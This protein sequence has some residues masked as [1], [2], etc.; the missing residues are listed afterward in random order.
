M[1]QTPNARP[2]R[3]ALVDDYDV[4]LA[5]LA[6]MFDHYADRIEV[7]EIDVNT[8]LKAHVDIALYDSFAQP[9]TDHQEIGALVRSGRADHVVV[10]TWNFQP[11]LVAEASKIGISGYLSKTLPARDLVT[12]LEAVHAGEFVV[13]DVPRRAGAVSGLDWP[14][15]HEGFTDRESEI[16][17]LI[18]QGKT[19]AEVASITY[20]SPNTVKT[21][22]RNIYR[23]IGAASRT[24]AVLWGVAHGFSPNQHRIDD[25][26]HGSL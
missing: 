13:S 24:Q 9:E 16:L 21:H 15:R 12:A 7:A 19:N 6:H 26:T 10:Y 11:E 25:W 8:D 23:K 1:G 5:G 17:A 18:T 22:I 4:V 20:T 2:I 14:G 3:V